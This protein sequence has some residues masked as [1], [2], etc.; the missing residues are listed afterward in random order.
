M[1]NSH[2]DYVRRLAKR[3]DCRLVKSRRRA[4]N[5][6]GNPYAV[7]RNYTNTHLDLNQPLAG[8]EDSIRS[9][10]ARTRYRIAAGRLVSRRR[11][12]GCFS[13]AK[14]MRGGGIPIRK[15]SAF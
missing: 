8:A 3:I 4:D 1:S 6:N 14:R 5:W 13:P 15:I 11:A 12:L 9:E 7:V 10:A 2:E